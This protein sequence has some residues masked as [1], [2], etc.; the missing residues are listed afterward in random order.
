[1]TSDQLDVELGILFRKAAD[2]RRSVTGQS[3]KARSRSNLENEFRLD[4]EASRR[5]DQHKIE[6]RCYIA[7]KEAERVANEIRKGLVA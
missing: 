3:S 2:G 7:R 5:L 1:M 6:R 4:C